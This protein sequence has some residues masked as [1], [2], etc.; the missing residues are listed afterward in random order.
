MG[1]GNTGIAEPADTGR[2]AGYHAKRNIGRD[3]RLRFFAAASEHKRIAAFQAQH[4]MAVLSQFNQL[5]GNVLLVPTGFATALAG[6][7]KLGIGAHQRQN[8]F[9]DQRVINHFIGLFERIDRM[10]RQQAR[11]ARPC[12]GQPYPTGRKF[13]HAVNLNVGHRA[14]AQ[15]QADNFLPVFV[16]STH[17]AVIG[18]FTEPVNLLSAEQLFLPL[19]LSHAVKTT[20]RFKTQ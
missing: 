16:I 20:S 19:E 6:I 11:I 1:G 3:Q 8:I 18:G 4:A 12:P 9:R 10:Q 17:R 5:V 14:V 13:R 15:R 2:N 7:K